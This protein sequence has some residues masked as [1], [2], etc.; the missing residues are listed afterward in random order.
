MNFISVLIEVVLQNNKLVE[1]F[2]AGNDII[3]NNDN[4]NNQ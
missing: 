2:S 4:G 1:R 3:K